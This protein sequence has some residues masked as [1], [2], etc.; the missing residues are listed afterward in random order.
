MDYADMMRRM[1]KRWGDRVADGDPEDFAELVAFLDE[2][3]RTAKAAVTQARA[4]GQPAWTFENIGRACGV[5]K[6]AAEKRWSA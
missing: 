1:L 4:S 2:T 5:S 3:K 6:Q